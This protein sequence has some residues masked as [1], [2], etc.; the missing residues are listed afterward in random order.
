MRRQLPLLLAAWR[1]HLLLYVVGVV[2]TPIY[3]YDDSSTVT[4]YDHLYQRWYRSSPVQLSTGFIEH[5]QSLPEIP[6][7]VHLSWSDQ[8][9]LTSG[10]PLVEHGVRALQD[11]NPGW[12][13][14]VSNDSQVEGY[15]KSK[16]SS[17][18]FELLE[19]VHIGEKIDLWRLLKLRDEGGLFQHMDR[20][21]SR[22]LASLITSE[23]RMLLPTCHDDDFSQDFMCSAPGNRIFSRAVELN[24][25]RRR[26]CTV[27]G[28]RKFDL[29]A[30]GPPTFS[31]AISQVAFGFNKW[32]LGQGSLHL[33]R[34]ALG[35]TG[36]ITSGKEDPP[37]QTLTQLQH[38][39]DWLEGRDYFQLKRDMRKAGKASNWQSHKRP[40]RN[41]CKS[42]VA[43]GILVVTCLM[44][45]TLGLATSMVTN[46]QCHWP[47]GP[48]NAGSGPAGHGSR[49]VD[50]RRDSKKQ[51][52]QEEEVLLSVM[53][54]ASGGLSA[55]PSLVGVS[56]G[57]L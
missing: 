55:R 42:H 44:L 34:D 48:G 14:E 49:L 1:L 16:I 6:Q 3:L 43:V 27:L 32:P 26:Q 5:L 57:V 15:I 52:D 25:E 8:H 47:A 28:L 21:N 12:K 35:R 56:S 54:Q 20:L 53:A 4:L 40:V 31:D 17:S 9:I 33:A 23:T 29:L 41:P 19:G 51:A 37:C 46:L 39:C 50:G 38:G 2:L 45:A 18:D 7:R 13:I 11:L 10:L 30:L 36:L 22:T 24:L